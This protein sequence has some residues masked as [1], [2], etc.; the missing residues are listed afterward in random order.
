MGNFS[1]AE[2][3]NDI[4]R[5]REE[6][7][8][9]ANRFKADR[10]DYSPEGLKKAYSQR[11]EVLGYPQ[12]IAAYRR[13]VGEWEAGARAATADA[14]AEFFPVAGD[15]TEKL[16]AEMAVSR[17]LARPGIQDQAQRMAAVKREF[18]AMPASPERT[19]FAQE[20]T[21]R[22]SETSP[23]L[24][25]GL[26]SEQHP[27]YV[28]LKRRGEQVGALADSARR[29]VD[30]LDRLASSP[31]AEAPGATELVDLSALPAAQAAYPVDV[32][33]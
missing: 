32:R 23:E 2:L 6:I 18:N 1:L 3:H 17:I 19:L 14:R 7:V 9:Q 4:T 29:Q 33:L 8:G 16:A 15:A 27:E 24:F 21:A 13:Q 26:V 10:S 5:T 12:Q 28:E 20:C 25:E 11:V 30:A 22:W 31:D